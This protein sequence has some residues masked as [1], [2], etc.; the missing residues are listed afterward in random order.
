M[1]KNSKTLA[2]FQTISLLNVEGKILLSVIANLM[3][4]YNFTNNVH[5]VDIAIQKGGVPGVHV[6]GCIKHTSVL[7]KKRGVRCYLVRSCQRLSID[8]TQTCVAYL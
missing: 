8:D 4:R 2:Q 3:T 1:E 7:R 5:Y 6:S